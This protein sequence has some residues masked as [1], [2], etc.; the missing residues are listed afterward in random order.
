MPQQESGNRRARRISVVAI[1]AGVLA[2]PVAAAAA[3]STG[4]VHHEAAA[5]QSVQDRLSDI[6]VQFETA[7]TPGAMEAAD[8][9]NGPDGMIEGAAPDGIIENSTP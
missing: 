6:R 1:S 8:Q 4:A 5:S 7:F 3:A 2:G 9:T